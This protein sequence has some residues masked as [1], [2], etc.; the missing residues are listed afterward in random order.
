MDSNVWFSGLYSRRGAPSRILEILL[1]GQIQVVVSQQVLEEVVRNV[2]LKIP[3]HLGTLSALLSEHTPEV[4]SDP[5]L[6]EVTSWIQIVGLDDAPILAAVISA[7]VDYLVTANTRH[8]AP[9]VEWAAEKGLQILTPRQ[10]VEMIE[11]KS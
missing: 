6:D 11:G 7:G 3:Q 1:E 5:S 10:F 2:G 4:C 9:A 8:F